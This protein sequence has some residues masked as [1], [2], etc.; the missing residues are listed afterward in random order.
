MPDHVVPL[1]SG[2]KLQVLEEGDPRGRPIFWLHGTPGSRVTPAPFV[3]DAHAKK[4]RLIAYDRPG[5]GESTRHP[6]RSVAETGQEVVAI[7]DYLGI[8]RF[9][10]W[11]ISGGGAPALACAATLP[12][13]VV[14]AASL[15]GVAPFRAAG[16]DWFAGMG[17]L[18]ISEY[19]LAS[20][21]RA[22]FEQLSRTER[23]QLVVATGD[24]IREM[25]SSLTSD[26]DRAALTEEIADFLVR[27]VRE[28][29]KHGAEGMI[30][31]AVS[32]V[33]PWGFE[34]SSIRCPVQ[35]WQ[36]R[37]DRFVPFAH[38]EWLAAHL[39]KV[40][41]HL[42]ENEGHLS[43]LQHVPEVHAWLLSRF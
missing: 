29:L 21:D 28:G 24:Q 15:A 6:G 34:L 14:A 17:E 19:T 2:R 7:A 37:E 18:N 23:D 22:A 1:P 30:D 3:R 27:S 26:V 35:V 40:E 13:R 10:V 9:G 32:Q 31:D 11:G 42:K 39:P 4:I 8:D 20:T 12:K 33:S 41:A 5:Y 38:G 25:W 16:L 43:Q 36:G